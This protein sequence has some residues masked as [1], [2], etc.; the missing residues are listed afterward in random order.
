MFI[1]VIKQTRLSHID[2][3][4]WINFHQN[5]HPAPPNPTLPLALH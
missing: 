5:I 2:F 4:K 3:E 1:Y